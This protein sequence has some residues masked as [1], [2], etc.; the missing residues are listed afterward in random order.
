MVALVAIVA[1]GYP[2]LV[3]S[4][5]RPVR[6][7]KGDLA[8]GSR[9]ALIRKILVVVQFA[10][11]IFLIVATLGINRQIRYMRGKGLGYDQ[12]NILSFNMAGP[13]ASGYET[14]KTELL[15]FPGV[16][17]VTRT[18]EHPANVHSSVWDADWEGREPQVRVSLGFMFVGFDFFK[19]FGMTMAAGR[20]FSREIGSDIKEGYILNEA[21]V[22]AMG[23]R[24]P[25][26]KRLSIFNQPG[27]VIGVVRDFHFQPMNE[28]I[29]PLVLGMGPGLAKGNVFVRVA[30]DGTARTLGQVEG[31]WS[32]HFPGRPFA[33]GFFNDRLRFFYQP[34]R[35][36]VKLI[37]LFTLLAVFVSCLGLFGLASFMA[38][39]KTKEIGIRRVLGAPVSWITRR[40]TTEFTRFVVLANLVSWP[41]AY[42][43]ITRWL[44]GYAY[45][46]RPDWSMFAL[47]GAAALFVAVLTVSGQA[48]RA[49]RRNPVDSIRYQ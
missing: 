30:P 40:L 34:E 17:G 45:R 41:L 15:R 32:K 7:L 23:I 10:A 6:I 44:Q 38:E 4:A 13:L 28:A 24:E 35:Q 39:Q 31:V 43:A 37:G 5:F 14:F 25:V 48:Y 18:L 36:I 11:S 27:T 3:L 16:L 42:W 19:T 2:A 29:H 33:P 1:G 12:D 8:P 9:G 49:A 46:I 20:P 21:A 47:A 26:G 22:R